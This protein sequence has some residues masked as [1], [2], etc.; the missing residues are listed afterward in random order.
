MLTACVQ[1]DADWRE[2][3]SATL[4]RSVVETLVPKLIAEDIPLMHALVRDVFP[5]AD[6][7]LAPL[8]ALKTHVRSV[9]LSVCCFSVGVVCLMSTV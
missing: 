9:R 8:D 2:G 6:I 1:S 5:G 4:I 3:E 7:A